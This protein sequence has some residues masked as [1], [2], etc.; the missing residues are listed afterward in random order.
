MKIMICVILLLSGCSKSIHYEL[1]EM[2]DFE[3]IRVQGFEDPNHDMDEIYESLNLPEDLMK[4]INTY[5][6]LANTVNYPFFGAIIYYSNPDY[7][8]GFEY[9][10][11]YFNGLRELLEREDFVDAYI[12]A[13]NHIDE[14]AE[15]ANYDAGIVELCLSYFLYSERCQ[16][17]FLED[18]RIDVE[19]F[20]ALEESERS[21]DWIK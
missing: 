5:T 6:L 2:Y 16:E 7:N 14:I 9:V 1:G 13:I 12:Y 3:T 18:G 10:Y 19:G 21:L 15:V 17:I 11:E 4:E 20:N 8:M